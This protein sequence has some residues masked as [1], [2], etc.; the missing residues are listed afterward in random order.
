MRLPLDD[1]TWL[2]KSSNKNQTIKT[3]LV[4]L[5]VFLFA[6]LTLPQNFG[7]LMMFSFY[8][9]IGGTQSVV[10]SDGRAVRRRSAKP[11]T[12]VQLRF[13]PHSFSSRGDGM[14]YVEDLKS[15]DR[16]VV[17]VRV[18]PAAQIK[19]LALWLEFFICMQHLLL[20]PIYGIVIPSEIRSSSFPLSCF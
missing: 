15:S 11:F 19:A 9:S 2:L 12:T 3:P 13:G 17:R 20:F 10:W 18:S 4:H 1:K 5:G 8:G 6:L 16:K 14:V 7:R